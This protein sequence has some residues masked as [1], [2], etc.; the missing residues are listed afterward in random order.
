M[1]VVKQFFALS[2]V[3]AR[4]PEFT[5]SPLSRWPPIF[6]PGKKRIR[7]CGVKKGDEALVLPAEVGGS[8]ITDLW[9]LL[10]D[11]QKQS[12][13]LYTAPAS[14]LGEAFIRKGDNLTIALDAFTPGDDDGS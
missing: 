3:V 7:V 10:F 4:G 8:R 5:R 1:L 12:G 6:E 13:D 9:V 14:V 11:L 2:H